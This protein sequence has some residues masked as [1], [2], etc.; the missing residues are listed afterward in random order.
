M[1]IDYSRDLTLFLSV[2]CHTPLPQVGK[3]KVADAIQ[4]Q[5]RFGE[6]I[7]DI[8]GA[9]KNQ[10]WDK[11]ENILKFA[12]PPEEWVERAHEAREVM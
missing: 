1:D 9:I 4:L 2:I 3:V 6:I 11:L 10:K 7:G 8:F 12:P 5:Q